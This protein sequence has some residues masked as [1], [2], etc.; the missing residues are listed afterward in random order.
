MAKEKNSVRGAPRFELMGGPVCL[1]FVNTLDNRP[2]QPKELLKRFVDLLWFC[3]DTGLL[4]E[5]RVNRLIEHSYLSADMAAETLRSAIE[6]REAMYG[7]FAA[8]VNKQPVPRLALGVLNAKIRYA[9]EHSHLAEKDGRFVWEFDTFN[10]PEHAF[11]EVLWPIARSAAELLASEQLPLVRMCSSKTCQ[12]FFL[13]VSKNHRRQWCSMKQCGN[14]AKAR[15]FYAR[16]SKADGKEPS[17]Q[18]TQRRTEKSARVGKLSGRN[19]S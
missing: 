19:P 8:I 10:A 4:S 12:W 14:R 5:A 15:R 13:D 1:D 9:A 17:P 16:R 3:Q 7:V 2:S 6:M 18:G 11:D